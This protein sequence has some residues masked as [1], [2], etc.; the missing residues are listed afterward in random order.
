MT[1]EDNMMTTNNLDIM[2]LNAIFDQVLN[3]DPVQ[4]DPG[5]HAQMLFG[6]GYKIFGEREV[7]VMFKKYKH[8]EKI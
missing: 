6:W 2:A 3:K 8:T 1:M 4:E 5:A 7:A